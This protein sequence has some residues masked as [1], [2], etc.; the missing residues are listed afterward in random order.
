MN[1]PIPPNISPEADLYM[2]MD[3]MENVLAGYDDIIELELGREPYEYPAGTLRDLARQLVDRAS[4][5]R[6]RQSSP[7]AAHSLAQNLRIWMDLLLPLV[8]AEEREIA[9]RGMWTSFDEEGA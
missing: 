9:R 5:V 8:P 7:H 1:H 3:R 4:E 2:R 6:R